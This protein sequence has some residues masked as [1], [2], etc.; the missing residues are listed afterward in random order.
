VGVNQRVLY[1]I[2]LKYKNIFSIIE[3]TRRAKKL[4][5]NIKCNHDLTSS[6]ASNILEYI[7][8]IIIDNLW[9]YSENN[10]TPFI[11]VKET[12]NY[13]AECHFKND[14]INLID[15]E[16]IF[17]KGYQ[18]DKK[19]EGFGYGL[20][21]LKLLIEHYNKLLGEDATNLMSI[22]HS[23]NHIDNKIEQIFIV[24]NIRIEK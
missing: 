23:Q 17:E 20:Y 6:F 14:S 22:E 8:A 16:S 10:S 18:E 5:I 19:S 9:K 7:F 4:N 24:R 1:E 13:L 2:I 12:E 11:I 3:N 15:K 21:W